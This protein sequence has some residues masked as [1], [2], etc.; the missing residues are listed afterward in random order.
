[1]C[2]IPV[3]YHYITE[4]T[5]TPQVFYKYFYNHALKNCYGYSFLEFPADSFKPLLDP[6]GR[7]ISETAA[8]SEVRRA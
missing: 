7:F 5:S 6:G 1:M 4:Q 8:V 2:I 3:A